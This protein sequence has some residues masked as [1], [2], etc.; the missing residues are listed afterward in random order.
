MVDKRISQLPGV[1]T[2]AAN[3]AL[4]FVQASS[5]TT[6]K[7]SFDDFM[8]VIAVL[9]ALSAPATADKIAV[10]DDSASS[11]KGMTL[12]DLHKVVNSF[13]ALS[14]PD[15][16][17]VL[18]IYDASAT[19]SKKI[20]ADDFM[21]VVNALTALSDP[22]FSDLLAVYDAA[23]GATKKT[24]LLQAFHKL[25]DGW[26]PVASTWTYASSAS[27]KESG[28][29]RYKYSRGDRV[30]IVQGTN[31]F[32]YVNSTSYS[33]PNTTISLIGGSDYS[34]ANAAITA[35]YF[36]HDENPVGF[37]HWFNWTATFNGWSSNPANGI[38]RFRI[39]GNAVDVSIAQPSNG[40]SNATGCFIGAL[41]TSANIADESWVGVAW[42]VDNGSALS[43]PVR[44]VMGPNAGT[45]GF[46]TSFAG[47]GWTASGGKRIGGATVRY[48]IANA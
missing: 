24:T 22:A 41:P 44:V 14:A 37:P 42:G 1:A 30:K 16:D 33:A 9:G 12:L 13:T 15:A 11:A 5:S 29:V 39:S 6:R 32:F 23:G 34:V 2:P 28:D 25:A 43:A 8:K 35:A 48:E 4:P 31:K 26:I 17:D 47:G 20:R 3:D 36:S 18:S 45:L 21:K 10:Y 7:I 40:T 38:Y 19:A 46:H 27:V